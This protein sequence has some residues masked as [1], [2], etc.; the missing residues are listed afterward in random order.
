[1]RMPLSGLEEARLIERVNRFVAR[2]IWRGEEVDV[3]KRQG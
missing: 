2:I 3:Y 1:M